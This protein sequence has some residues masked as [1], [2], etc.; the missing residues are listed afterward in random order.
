MELMV[1]DK[2]GLS[3]DSEWENVFYPR[4]CYFHNKID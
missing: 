3:D 2:N 1:K 4:C